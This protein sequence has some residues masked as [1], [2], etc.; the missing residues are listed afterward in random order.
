MSNKYLYG[1]PPKTDGIKSVQ[2]WGSLFSRLQHT[3][4]AMGYALF[5]NGKFPDIILGDRRVYVR[6]WF[7]PEEMS[8]INIW[9]SI[10]LNLN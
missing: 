5:K 9:D 4:V 7:P 3:D 10:P 2:F 6:T 1:D 8:L